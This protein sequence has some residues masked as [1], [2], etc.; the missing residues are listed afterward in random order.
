M[1]AEASR[2]FVLAF[3]EELNRGD[4]RCW[5]RVAADAEWT[6]IASASDYPYPSVYTKDAYRALVAG[7]AADFPDGLS[8]TITGTTAE[9]DRVA[10]EAV[11]YGRTRG[12]RLYNNRYHLLILLQDGLIRTAREYL[13]SGHAAEVLVPER[14][15]GPA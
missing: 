1:D 9:P 5:D 13:D 11:S 3:F 7:A 2:A 14:A 4:P 10:V 12:G 6:L 15:G 8:F